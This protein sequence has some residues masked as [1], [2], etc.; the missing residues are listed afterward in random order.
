MDFFQK[1]QQPKIIS[2]TLI[3]LFFILLLFLFKVEE[4]GVVVDGEPTGKFGAMSAWF[5]VVV[6]FLVTVSGLF[7]AL[8]FDDIL[9][10]KTDEEKRDEVWI[11]IE[12]SLKEIKKKILN[13]GRI[14]SLIV[15]CDGLLNACEIDSIAISTTRKSPFYKSLYFVLTELR[16][17]QLEKYDLF[18][19]RLS[20]AFQEYNGSKADN[21]KKETIKGF[22]AWVVGVMLLDNIDFHKHKLFIKNVNT[23]E[24][25]EKELEI[26]FNFHTELVNSTEK[27]R[28]YEILNK[29]SQ[30]SKD[31]KEVKDYL[32]KEVKDFC[33]FLK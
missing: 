29:I 21:E 1:N 24:R 9:K 10:K 20:S 5:N 31:I 16:T 28:G 19:S 6:T 27:S 12:G 33:G 17:L 14:A 26:Y 4:V 13:D 18:F 25:I 32:N 7:L 30:D 8:Q 11:I 23:K 3:V 22:F 2:I 15:L